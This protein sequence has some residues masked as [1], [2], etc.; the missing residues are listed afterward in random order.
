M[1]GLAGYVGLDEQTGR[2]LLQRMADAQAH[3]GPDGE[4][5]HAAGRVGLAHRRLA[6]IDRDGGEQP[7]RSADGR[8][9]AVYN[10]EIYNYR[11]LRSEL[12]DL[13]HT[14]T[15][16]SDTEVMLAAWARW[17]PD[18]L[19]RFNG[20]F[21]LAIADGHTGEVTLA[22]DQFGI[23]PLYL[24]EQP[25]L[26][27]FASEIR[28]LLATGRVPRVPDDVT[29]Y[30]YLRFRVH[31]DGER[32]F[33]AGISRL[34]PGQLAVI[35]PDGSVTRRTYTRL[36]DDLQE[37]A[38]APQEYGNVA[39]KRFRQ[40]LG[41][42]I[43]RRL[44]SDV[45]VGTALSGGLDSST[46]V[47]TIDRLLAASDS[48]AVAVGDRQQTFSAVFPGQRNDEERYVDA[49]AAR[50]G[51]HL[52]VHKVR[53]DPEGFLADLRDFVRT[54]EEPVIS[55][56]PYAQYC[57]MREASQYVTVMVDG[58]GAD[59]MLAGYL[60]YHLVRL[61]S[62]RRRGQRV[63]AVGE[64]VR[65]ADVLWRLGRFRALDRLRRRRTVPVTAMLAPDFAAAHARER[66]PVIP[67][68]I[69]ARLA[70]DLFRN[71]LPALLR[72]EDRNT[73]R[74]SIE[75]RVPF[76][77]PDLLR[78]VWGVDERAIVHNG[79][80]K[81]ALRDA[82]VELLPELV[83]KRRNKI[84]FTTPEDAWF[85]RI[86]ND[87]Y[88]VFTS[89][90]FG[91]R[92]YVNAPAVRAAFAQHLEGRAGADTMTFWRLLNLELWLRE[93]I[94]AEQP[95]GST[96]AAGATEA[97]IAARA[98]AAPDGAGPAAG[99]A[100]PAAA[101]GDGEGADGAGPGR[102][103]QAPAKSDYVPN[104]GK[105]LV[106]VPPPAPDEGGAE[107]GRAP[108]AGSPPAGGWARFPL[109]VDLVA[110]GD[111]IPALA[112]RRAGEFFAGLRDAPAGVA[113]LTA[114]RWYL[115]LSEKI[116]AIAQGRS[117]FT[118]QVRPS[119]WARVLSRFVVR[120][121][122]GI[123]LG[124]PVT[125]H[126]AI[127]EIGLPRVLA[128]ASAGLAGKAVGRRGW[129]YR[130]AGAQVRA[131]DGPTEYSAYPANVSAKLAPKDPDLVAG[132]VSAAVRA[133]LDPSV[134]GRFG[135]TVI[136]DA[137]DLGRNV[138]GHDTGLDHGQLVAA[139]A[140]N[141]LGQG[142]QQTPVAIVV[143][144]G[145]RASRWR[146]WPAEGQPAPAGDWSIDVR[147]PAGTRPGTPAAAGS[148]PGSRPG[149][150]DGGPAGGVRSAGEVDPTS[151][152]V[153]D[154]APATPETDRG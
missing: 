2:P 120:T 64:L 111:D 94:D 93:F 101:I 27:L 18:A 19:D 114:G 83:H 140:D 13:G 52:R 142:R 59:E 17:G 43:G 37:L 63:R 7:M 95:P 121:P 115:Y 126:L 1:C 148:R 67:D 146:P 40:A 84:G 85:E 3:R 92:P 128:A 99:G 65:S 14:F 25:G 88:A 107:P 113:G 90:E 139:F 127:Q 110:P 79:W 75:G 41:T 5:F 22:R 21:A 144:L 131:I 69:K 51:Q 98:S 10:G 135:G 154:P 130:V 97:G 106:L 6:I 153:G 77:D 145:T 66:F 117:Y 87:V 136:I 38:A 91:R 33:F 71:S 32:T 137:N 122:H 12:A 132:I 39:R 58:Q 31:D 76:L 150:P 35:A 62:L 44:V 133:G 48:A 152:A 89:D 15:T 9:V 50:C 151:P 24:T 49:V 28:P 78:V 4:G 74:F 109:R 56:G 123:G 46:I 81:K 149:S 118:W 129:F 60:P 36:Y 54:Q 45:P 124:H 82:T 100:G 16:E 102:H 104:E 119:R 57:V 105:D 61:R 26:T 141:P 23:K 73:M 112:A 80:N 55:T 103:P 72:Y 108:A 34:L 86:K 68:D 147:R 29:I 96:A 125:M 42:A 47:A 30:R 70:D 134:A 8:Y 20:M 143:E 53:P 138:L 116:V 11:E